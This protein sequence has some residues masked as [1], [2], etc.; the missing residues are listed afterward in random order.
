MENNFNLTNGTLSDK[1]MAALQ[2]ANISGADSRCLDNETS[3]L[4]A[5]IRVAKPLDDDD[6]FFLD[7]NIGSLDHQIQ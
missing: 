5:F 1:L 2:G 6:S 3:S 4:S 7:L